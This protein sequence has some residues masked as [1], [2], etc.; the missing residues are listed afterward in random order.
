MRRPRCSNSMMLSNGRARRFV[1]P[2]GEQAR[3]IPFP[4]RRQRDAK[5]S[6]GLGRCAWNGLGHLSLP[7]L[8]WL[9]VRAGEW[10]WRSPARSAIL[11]DHSVCSKNKNDSESFFVARCLIFVWSSSHDLLLIAT[12][13]APGGLD[14]FSRSAAWPYPTPKSRFGSTAQ[15]PSQIMW[16]FN[17]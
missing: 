9:G 8:R 11:S 2:G 7:F 17:E 3:R 10:L 16:E 13:A 12:D 5:I 14:H 15:Y 6:S 4:E 1:A